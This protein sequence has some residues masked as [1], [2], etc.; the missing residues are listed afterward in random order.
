MVSLRCMRTFGQHIR[1]LRQAQDISLREMAKRL[2]VSAAFISDVE[3]GRRFPSDELLVSI[4]K[5][6]RVP[7]SELKQVDQRPPIEDLKKKAEED[8]QYALAL[9]TLLDSKWTGQEILEL[10]REKTKI[11]SPGAGHGKKK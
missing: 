8:S 1:V 5:L 2:A 11:P 3:L 9:R 7:V 4:A 6:L 10:V